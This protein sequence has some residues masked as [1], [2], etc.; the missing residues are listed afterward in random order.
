MPSPECQIYLKGITMKSIFKPVLLAGLLTTFGFSAFSQGPMHSMNGPMGSG[1]MERM[2]PERMH[3]WMEKQNQELKAKLKLTA[4]QE[5]A[6]TT[7][8]AAMKPP[9]DMG[10]KRQA[11]DELQKLP[12]PE[13]IDKMK[14]L[15][16]QHMSEMNLVMDQHGEAMKSFYAVLTPEQKKIF[17]ESAMPNPNMEGRM[18]GSRGTK[19][20]SPPARP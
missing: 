10:E 19:M 18:G 9:A 8:M 3:S 1:P 6:W 12:T 17:D 4:A 20:M 11:H 13:R 15:R 7:Y 2:S 14:A 5:S 16:A